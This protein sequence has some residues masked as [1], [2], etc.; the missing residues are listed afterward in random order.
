MISAEDKKDV[1][2]AYGKAL[3]TKVS[4]ATNDKLAD[5]LNSYLRRNEK[6]PLRRYQR[7]ILFR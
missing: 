1:S 2:K 5:S 6:R 3:A 7:K 4:R